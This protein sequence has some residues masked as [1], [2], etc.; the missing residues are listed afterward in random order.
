MVE[1]RSDMPLSAICHI[2]EKVNSTGVPLDVFDLCTAILWAQGFEL[3]QRWETTRQTLQPQVRMQP[4]SGTYFLQGIA[5]LDSLE[6]KRNTGT[7]VSC[8]KQDLM[9]LKRETLEKWWP[10]LEAGYREAGKFMTDQGILSERILPYSTILMPLA[11]IFADLKHRMGAAYIGTAWDKITRWYWCSI[12]SQRYGSQVETL[13]ALD[14]EQVIRWVDD[15]V[16]PDVV[17]TFSFRA[18][19][20]QEV[21]S[22]RNAMYKGVLCLLARN[23]AKDFGGGGY[24][25]TALFMETNQ[26]HHHIFPKHALKQL[27]VTD[28]RLDTVIN[29]TLI[30][31]AVNRSIGG[32]RPSQ[33]IAAWRAKLPHFDTILESHLIDPTILSSDNWDTFMRDRRERLRQLIAD[34]CGGTV[35]PFSDSIEV[36]IPDDDSIIA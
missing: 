19:I 14:F 18:D 24:L 31:A 13:G 12:F 33:Y 6:R 11:A 5:L 7:S 27:G 4:L 10:I 30:N 20:L 23:Q 1:L 15:D 8:R 28:S 3:N 2:F 9:S 34:V 21:T 25:S 29:K 26:D 16:L 22:L 36:E 35:Q 32:H 17:R